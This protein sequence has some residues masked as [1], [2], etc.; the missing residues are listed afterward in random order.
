[1]K[2]S[3]FPFRR[4]P[5]V[6]PMLG[7]EMRSTGEVMGIDQDFGL[8]YAKAQL[9]AGQVL[10]LQGGVLFS[11]KDPDKPLMAPLV[12]GYA[13]RWLSGLCHP[14]H[15]HLPGQ[16]RHRGSGRGP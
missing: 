4:F 7:P 9:A 3:V 15:G 10:P 2:E 11:V 5:G 12:K 6:D 13:G 8:A 1:M 16:T 14:G